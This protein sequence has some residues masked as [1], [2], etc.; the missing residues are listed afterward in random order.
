MNTWLIGA[1]P[2]SRMGIVSTS[3]MH[4]YTFRVSSADDVEMIQNPC[5]KPVECNINIFIHTYV[6][7]LV[8]VMRIFITAGTPLPVVFPPQWDAVHKWH[9][10]QGTQERVDYGTA[11]PGIES[12]EG[13]ALEESNL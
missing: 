13:Y 7:T 9:G 3:S 12:H 5:G 1:I 2:K 4:R 6:R 8:C 11:P 10:H